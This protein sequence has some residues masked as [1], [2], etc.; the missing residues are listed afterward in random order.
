[1]QYCY[2]KEIHLDFDGININITINSKHFN[3]L[4]KFAKGTV[5][6]NFTPHLS[7][8]FRGIL[9]TIYVDLKKNSVLS[10]DLEPILETYIKENNISVVINK[11][12]TLG[13]NPENDITK[14][15]VEKLNKVIPSLDLK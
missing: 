1:M 9:S 4:D 6:F 12:S 11:N 8:M 5:N 2:D 13:G 3:K 15:I 10:Q 14:I 7:P